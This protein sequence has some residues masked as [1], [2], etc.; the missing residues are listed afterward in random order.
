SASV[1]PFQSCGRRYTTPIAE[2]ATGRMM[3]CTSQNAGR[4]AAAA[5]CIAL[6]ISVFANALLPTNASQAPA[7]ART[8]ARAPP[9]A[10]EPSSAA[11]VTHSVVVF[12]FIARALSG[13]VSGLCLSL[14]AIREKKE[15]HLNS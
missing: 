3:P 13:K 2:P 5:C 4:P 8:G 10:S 7:V 15:E 9:A 14:N 12:A 6:V 1:L 11:A